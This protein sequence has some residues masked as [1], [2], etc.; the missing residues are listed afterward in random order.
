MGT[1]GVLPAKYVT[2]NEA[3]QKIIEDTPHFTSGRIFLLKSE[4]I[5][6]ERNQ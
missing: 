3:I 1:N 5:R 4:A 6:K 2:E